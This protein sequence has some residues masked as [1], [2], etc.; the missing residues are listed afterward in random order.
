MLSILSR[1]VYVENTSSIYL[2]QNSSL[3]TL[4]RY[5]SLSL[6]AVFGF[7]EVFI[8]FP[9]LRRSRL[10]PSAEDL[11]ACDIEA[12]YCTQEKSPGTH[13][14][15]QYISVSIFGFLFWP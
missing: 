8:V 4:G 9:R 11:S 5:Q 15:F 3:I 10:R 14:T 7:G 12:S 1:L 2:F 13:C 6:W